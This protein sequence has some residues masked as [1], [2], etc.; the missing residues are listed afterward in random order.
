MGLPQISGLIA[1]KL[2]GA[3]YTCTTKRDQQPLDIIELDLIACQACDVVRQII[4]LAALVGDR[5]QP[6]QGTDFGRYITGFKR[7]IHPSN[8]AQTPKN[9][10]SLEPLKSLGLTRTAAPGRRIELW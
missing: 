1:G 5:M 7:L 4:E 6:C 9:C 8:I 2:A 3:E 10:T